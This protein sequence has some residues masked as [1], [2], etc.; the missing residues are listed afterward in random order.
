M[1][2]KVAFPEK[3]VVNVMGDLAFSTVGLDIETA[4][5]CNIPTLTVVINNSYMSIYD[6]SRFPT[7]IEKY[8]IKS[9]SGQFSEVAAAMG[10]YAEKI[11]E[12]D[13]IVSAI[14]RGIEAN[15]RGEP[16]VLEFITRDEGNF[17]KF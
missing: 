13:D 4:V 5:R 11:T 12:P 6:D 7:A 8:Q 10:A 3:Q 15:D 17:S 9:L 1:G 2:A 16:A 14:K